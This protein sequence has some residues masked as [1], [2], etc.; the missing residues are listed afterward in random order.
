MN[1]KIAGG[2][3]ENGS[4]VG[5]AF[6]KYGSI[7]PIVRW[8]M[9]GFE[10]A[11]SDFVDNSRP[12]KNL[13][14]ECAEGYWVIKWHKQGY[15]AKGCDFSKGVIGIASENART[16]EISLSLFKHKSIYELDSNLDKADL[17]VCCEVL[18]HLEAP[19]LTLQV[20]QRIVGQHLIISVPN[21]PLWRILNIARA[22]YMTHGGNT[23]GHIQHWSKKKLIESVSHYFTIVD[24]K[25]LLQWTM[26][27]CHP[28]RS[29]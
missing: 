17:I 13:E 16:H 25:S 26:L 29:L 1:I 14:I 18:E 2:R 19:S 21:E 11:L 9:T 27:Y 20:L 23:P 3:K 15:S 6:D 12:E 7:Y 4:V 28:R 8:M 10:S 24:I 5:N 22:K